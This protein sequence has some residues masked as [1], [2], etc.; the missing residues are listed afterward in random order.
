MFKAFGASKRPCIDDAS[1][2]ATN[3][4]D[5]AHRML[6]MHPLMMSGSRS[7]T[8]NVGTQ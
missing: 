5:A 2:A 4:D 7:G 1:A 6:E 3:T 8:L